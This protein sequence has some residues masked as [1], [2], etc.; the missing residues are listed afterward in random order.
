MYL[1]TVILPW[2]IGSLAIVNFHVSQTSHEGFIHSPKY[3]LI[4]RK[5]VARLSY[6]VCASVA[7][8]SPRNFDTCTMRH[9]CITRTNAVRHSCDSLEKTWEQS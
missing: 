1:L 5:T 2:L 8:M 9:F 6:D 4:R 7:N 3:S